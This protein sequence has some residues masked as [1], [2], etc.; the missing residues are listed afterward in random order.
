MSRTISKI[1]RDELLK[2]LH[3]A[4]VLA[5]ELDR[6]W[7]AFAKVFSCQDDD[8]DVGIAI[9]SDPADKSA[10]RTSELLGE[11]LKAKQVRVRDC[12]VSSAVVDRRQQMRSYFN[13]Q[14]GSDVD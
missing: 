10:A 14:G 7:D 13:Q 3:T 8:E 6:K 5:A 12:N 11:L 1:Q 4:R 9:Y 2:Q